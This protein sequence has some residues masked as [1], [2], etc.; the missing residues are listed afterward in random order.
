MK[1]GELEFPLDLTLLRLS[2]IQP[3][4]QGLTGV[5][6]RGMIKV[7]WSSSKLGW[8]DRVDRAAGG[9]KQEAA[10][11]FLVLWQ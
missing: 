8:M 9:E 3:L 6:C 4:L 7:T 2:T 10:I 11:M 1:S 5:C